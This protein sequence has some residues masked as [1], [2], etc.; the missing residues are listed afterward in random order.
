LSRLESAQVHVPFAATGDDGTPLD[1][2][3]QLTRIELEALTKDLVDRTVEVTS[4]VLQAGALGPEKLDEIILVGGQSQAP[5]VRQAV[6]ELL[7][8]A[9]RAD[10][11]PHAA[12]ALGAAILGHS[13]ARAEL[14]RRGVSLSEVLS[15]PIAIGIRGGGVRRVLERNT[16]L[17][18]EK[19]LQLSVKEGEAVSIAIFQGS[20]AVAEENEYLGSVHQVA[21]RPGELT[22]TFAISPDATLQVSAVAPGGRKAIAAMSTQDATDEVRASLLAASPL[23]GEPDQAANGMWGGLKRLFG[24]NAPKP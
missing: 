10:V 1:V 17:P 3:T 2:R 12:V 21:D 9:G 4:A 22:L 8:K 13:L 20:S 5:L 16:R 14:G 15:A 18:A 19:T 24:K 11:D 23:P 6:A 7:G